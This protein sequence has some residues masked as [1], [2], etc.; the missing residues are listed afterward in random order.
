MGF[1][2][3]PVGAG[4]VANLARPGG[5][6][7]GLAVPTPEMAGKRLQLLLEVAPTVARIAVLSDRSYSGIDLRETEAAAG[8]LGGQLQ[9]WKVRSGGELD[10]AFTVSDLCRRPVHVRLERRVD[11]AVYRRRNPVAAAQLDYLSSEPGQLDPLAAERSFP[12]EV[13]C[14]GGIERIIASVLSKLSGGSLI[15][16]ARPTARVS[17]KAAS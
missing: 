2:S 11:K 3:D 8:A 1:A 10:R 9:V 4:L 17:R 16:S 13:V 12:I 15:P 14:W 6:I 5:N 7:T